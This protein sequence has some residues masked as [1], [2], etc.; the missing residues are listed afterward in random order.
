M[1]FPLENREEEWVK[2]LQESKEIKQLLDSKIGFE[3]GIENEEDTSKQKKLENLYPF[4]VTLEG[5][6]LHGPILQKDYGQLENQWETPPEDLP[7]DITK[8]VDY[9]SPSIG[10]KPE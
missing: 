7:T 4:I 6:A 3:I 10:E 8:L 1:S 9:Q 2:E 5:N